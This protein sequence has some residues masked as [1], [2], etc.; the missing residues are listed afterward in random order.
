MGIQTGRFSRQDRYIEIDIS[1]YIDDDDLIFLR[2]WLEDARG[3]LNRREPSP[4]EAMIYLEKALRLVNI[5][6]RAA[7]AK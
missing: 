5:A 2:N 4:A 3:A 6:V 7:G 1:E